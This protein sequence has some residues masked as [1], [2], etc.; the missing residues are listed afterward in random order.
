MNEYSSKKQL[1]S[2][3]E[4]VMERNSNNIKDKDEYEWQCSLRESNQRD[5]EQLEPPSTNDVLARSYFHR[6]H[7]SSLWVSDPSLIDQ[8]PPIS[9]SNF[10]SSLSGDLESK[11]HR[12][13]MSKKT[14]ET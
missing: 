9:C 13:V 8:A 5:Y 3:M 6:G 10:L 1:R 11:A 4:T 7:S 14:G 12:V 2:V